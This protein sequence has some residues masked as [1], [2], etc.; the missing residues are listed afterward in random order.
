MSITFTST[1][2]GANT[3]YVKYLWSG[4]IA[5]NPVKTDVYKNSV[6][7]DFSLAP[8]DSS[9]VKLTRGSY[10]NIS[11]ALYPNWFT[12]YVITE[13]ELVPLGVKGG[14]MYWGYNY[15]ATA[16]EYILSLKPLG[17]MLPFYNCTAG[18]ILKSLVAKLVPNTFDVSNIQDGPLVAQYIVDPNSKFIDVTQDF[19]ETY[20]YRFWGNNKKLNF[21]PQDDTIGEV[22]LDGS[23]QTFTPAALT[24][25]ASQDPILNDITVQGFIEPQQYVQEYFLGTGFDSSF[26]LAAGV[27]GVDTTLLISEQFTGD[28]ISNTWQVF[29]TSAVYLVVDNGYLNSLGGDGSGTYS[30]RLESINPLPLEGRLRLT[31]GEWDFLAGNGAICGLWS[32]EPTSGFT[33]CL[34]CLKVNGTTI[35]PVVNGTLDPTQFFVI[36]YTKRYIIRTLTECTQTMRTRQSFGFIDRTGTV[37]SYT[38]GAKQDTIVYQ[39]LISETDPDTGALLKQVSFRNTATLTDAQTYAIYIPLASD[40]LHAT[41]SNITVSIPLDATLEFAT[42]VQLINGGFDDWGDSTH[43]TGWTGESTT[44]VSQETTMPNNGSALRLTSTTGNVPF[45]AQFVPM[46]ETGTTYSVFC[47]YAAPAGAT[48]SLH[49]TISGTGVSE[50]GVVVPLTILSSDQTYK[51]LYGVLTAPLTTIPTDLAIKVYWTSGVNATA[52]IVDD[53]FVIS[54]WVQQIVGPNEID[55]M[56]GLAPVATIVQGNTGSDTRNSYTGSF[57]YNAG[58]SQLVFFAD[59]ITYTSDTPPLN[60]VIRLGYRAAGGAVGR[61]INSASIASEA[62]A[63]QDNG[64]RSI[65]RNDL[66]PR[67]RTSEECELAAAALVA[68]NC[69][70][71]Y[72]GTYT[73]FSDFF[74]QEPKGGAIMK[75]INLSN[76]AVIQAEEI[77]QVVT[78]LESKSPKERFVHVITYGKPD[79]TSRLLDKFAQTRG[80]FLKDPAQPTNVP[81]VDAEVI[82]MNYAD[83]VVKPFLFGW[84]D[85]EICIDMGQDLPTN[86]LFYELRFGDTGWGC[87]DGKNLIVRATH[88]QIT[89]PRDL[90][91]KSVFIR[92]VNQGNNMTFSEDQTQSPFYTKT[93]MTL[94]TYK[95]VG[96]SGNTGNLTQLNIGS[97]GGTLSAHPAIGSASLGVWTI[98]ILGT[99]GQTMTMTLRGSG[100]VQTFQCTGYWQRVS[101]PCPGGWTSGPIF[102]LSCTNNCIVSTTQYSV[103]TGT[104]AETSYYPT[105][106]T[107]YGPQSR[108]STLL[109]SSFPSAINLANV[110]INSLVLQPTY[111]SIGPPSQVAVPNVIGLTQAA[112]TVAIGA[113]GLVLGTVVSGGGGTS[114]TVN[115]ENPVAG[116]MVVPTSAVNIQVAP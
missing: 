69:F 19:T 1:M 20:S 56:D 47:R 96:P 59:S 84:D 78:T 24:F 55:S 11:S 13:P 76:M 94:T 29:D 108:Y 21:V 64:V 60:Q 14:V 71:H 72:E 63:W 86:G 15:R 58:Q 36:D 42:M 114:G 22:I 99:L 116:T 40:T 97:G 39:T 34:Y 87:G 46:L 103:E 107:V 49:V 8:S 45:V 95:G 77:N 89:I 110:D 85:K 106:A 54:D 50:T 82:G 44:G 12:G 27:Y 98:G 6:Y 17:V 5:K 81:A 35:N 57:Q 91:G 9:F 66:S 93:N 111:S 73:H 43:P 61:T 104:D 18:S 109:K 65:V 92:Q 79:R 115:L 41:V 10:I 38:A 2:P 30:A 23:S 26:N 67:P 48:G 28:T 112:A 80:T 25:V 52:L 16:D 100:V 53:L 7:V 37:G 75:F 31:H 74:S 88:R 3:D 101:F 102:D 51:T 70:T 83:D 62:A 113:A 68:E 33:N 90:R 105:N 4:T 32:Q